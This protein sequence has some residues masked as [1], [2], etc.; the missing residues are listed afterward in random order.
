MA[1]APFTLRGLVAELA[2]RGL[3]GDYSMLRLIG[4]IRSSATRNIPGLT[5]LGLQPMRITLAA[6]RPITRCGI[7]RIPRVSASR[8]TA[9]ASEQDRLKDR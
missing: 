4:F 1:E 6:N 9:L 2:A 8:K 5:C 7:S 3:R